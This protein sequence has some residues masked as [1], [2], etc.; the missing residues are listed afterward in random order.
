MKL[1][2]F[3]AKGG[4]MKKTE[5]NKNSEYLFNGQFLS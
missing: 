5:V 4:F 3:I 2:S 1:K